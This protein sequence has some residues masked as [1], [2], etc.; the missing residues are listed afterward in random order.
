[1]ILT[2]SLMVQLMNAFLKEIERLHKSIIYLYK[3]LSKSELID[4]LKQ[5]PFHTLVFSAI[6][7][8][9]FSKILAILK[10]SH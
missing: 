5:Q 7:K 2:H 1:M 3:H 9:L 10:R 4:C 6:I 8:R